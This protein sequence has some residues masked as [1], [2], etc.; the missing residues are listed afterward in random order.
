[1]GHVAAMMR[2]RS[3]SDFVHAQADAF[4][5]NMEMLM[6]SIRRI[7]EIA[8]RTAE[9]SSHVIGRNLKPIKPAD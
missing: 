9:E 3:P 4:R 1:M 8:L 7:A 6:D 2:C 5:D